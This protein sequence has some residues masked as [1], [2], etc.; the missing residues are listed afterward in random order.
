MCER[1][2]S[3]KWFRK[4]T[5]SLVPAALWS[6]SGL[7]CA[8][9][10]PTPGAGSGHQA[11]SETV[12]RGSLHPV[13]TGEGSPGDSQRP[14]APGLRW[15][16]AQTSHQVPSALA[17]AGPS[18]APSL[19]PPGMAHQGLADV[20]GLQGAWTLKRQ[21]PVPRP[22]WRCSPRTWFLREAWP[23]RRRCPSSR[24]PSLFFRGS[25][26]KSLEKDLETKGILFQECLSDAVWSLEIEPLFYHSREVING[27]VMRHR[28]H[29]SSVLTPVSCSSS[30]RCRGGLG[31][32]CP[33]APWS[34]AS[35][36]RGRVLGRGI[37][38]APRTAGE[39]G[40][41]P[42]CRPGPPGPSGHGRAMVWPPLSLTASGC[43]SQSSGHQDSGCSGGSFALFWFCLGGGHAISTNP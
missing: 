17:S 23:E 35:Q 34:G 11:P 4:G 42:H 14:E 18:L 29:V 43:G 3:G 22:C 41:S 2:N 40:S 37:L 16:R 28:D 10:L 9:L 24:T 8:P 33:P 1:G 30:G 27:G 19:L 6:G 5:G 26:L 12:S 20:G 39:G 38:Q 13:C 32:S 31:S 36:P 25:D 15:G 7:R 21:R